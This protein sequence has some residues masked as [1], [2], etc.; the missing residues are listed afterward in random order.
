MLLEHRRQR[1]F[2]TLSRK[3]VAGRGLAHWQSS[4]VKIE[5]NRWYDICIDL[6]DSRVCCYLDRE[7]IHCV[8]IRPWEPL[9]AVAGL[10]NVKNEIVLKRW[11]IPGLF[12]LSLFRFSICEE[13]QK[14]NHI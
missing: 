4:S 8:N 2:L 12:F 14:S 9:Y 10:S 3:D 5:S 13:C 11:S 7:L 6:K 1:E